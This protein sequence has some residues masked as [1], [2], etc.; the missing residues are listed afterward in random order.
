MAGVS[1]ANPAKFHRSLARP[2]QILGLLVVAEADEEGL[3][4]LMSPLIGIMSL[5]RIPTS[6]GTSA[7]VITELMNWTCVIDRL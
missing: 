6:T 1:S 7:D 5:R 4:I 2:V 3:P